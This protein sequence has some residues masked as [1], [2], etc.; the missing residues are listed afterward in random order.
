MPRMRAHDR[1][2]L[3]K[4]THNYQSR[5][6]FRYFHTSSYTYA[7]TFPRNIGGGVGSLKEYQ[8]L[9]DASVVNFEI[10]RFVLSAPFFGYTMR[11]SPISRYF[12]TC[13][14]PSVFTSVPFGSCTSKI[15]LVASESANSPSW[16]SLW[17]M[18]FLYP[19]WMP[20]LSMT[21]WVSTK[22]SLRP[23][24]VPLFRFPVVSNSNHAYT[25]L[26]SFPL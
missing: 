13:R 11:V 1:R 6:T 25:W 5:K 20:Y 23:V 22:K 8:G 14:P 17:N 4:N 3:V 7:Q 19:S 24:V 26:G 9:F 12:K 18:G 16:M 10:G 15:L 2:F 21:S